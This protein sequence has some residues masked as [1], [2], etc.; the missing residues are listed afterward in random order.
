M[1]TEALEDDGMTRHPIFEE[2]SQVGY[3]RTKKYQISLA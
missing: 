3:I 1:P 2:S